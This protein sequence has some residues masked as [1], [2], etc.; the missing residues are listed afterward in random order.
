MPHL[1]ERLEWQADLTLAQSHAAQGRF[2]ACLTACQKIISTHDDNA[3]A[4][5]SVG[6][7]L[8]AFGFLSDARRCFL[9]IRSIAPDDLRSLVNLAN[10]SR[11]AGEHNEARRLYGTLLQRLPDHS[12]IRR[13]ALVSLEYDPEVS[14][15]GRLAQAK[16]WGEWAIAR[17]GSLRERPLLRPLEGRPLRVGYISADFCQHTVG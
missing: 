17:T 5:L 16:A 4:L 13:N 6:A 15:S 1:P 8:L 12:V 7:L 9:R 10:L 3:D 2:D 11:D 14:N